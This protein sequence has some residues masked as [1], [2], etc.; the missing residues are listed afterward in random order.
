MHTVFINIG[1]NLGQRRLNLS[2]AMS[3]VGREF[4]DF[5]MSHVVETD[6]WGY[7]SPNPFLNVGIAF[8]T[9]LEPEAVLSKLQDIE[10]SISS[11]PHR[12]SERNYTDRVIDID[13]VAIDRLQIDSDTLKVPHPHLA[14]REFFLKPMEELASG[15]RHP[16]TGES[17]S[18]ML[19]KLKSEKNNLL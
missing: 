11:S 7:D 15:W 14:E 2:R 8:A 16:A 1:S 4:G 12:D 17:P 3:A 10:R 5:E 13:I 18:E 6:P 9:E 19:W